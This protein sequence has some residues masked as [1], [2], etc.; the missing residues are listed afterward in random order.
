METRVSKF[1]GYRKQLMEIDGEALD[2]YSFSESGSKMRT[3]LNDSSNVLPMNQVMN[4]LNIEEQ[5]Q[6]RIKKAQRLKKL[7]L[8]LIIAGIAVIIIALVVVGIIVFTN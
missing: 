2:F 1:K 8:F 4:Q 6:L 5:E 7:K 3:T